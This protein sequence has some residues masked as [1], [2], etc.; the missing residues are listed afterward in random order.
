M[1][2]AAAKLTLLLI[3]SAN[4]SLLAQNRNITFKQKQCTVKYV[5]DIIVSQTNVD[6]LY[7]PRDFHDAPLMDIDLNNASIDDAMDTLK[8]KQP[9]LIFNFT[10]NIITVTR[11]YFDIRGKVITQDELPAVG[12]TV[13]VLGTRQ[14][15]TT[16]AGGFYYL[17]KVD[18]N[19]SLELTSVYTVRR[20]VRILNKKPELISVEKFVREL[21]AVQIS[22]NSGYVKIS[23]KT[24]AAPFHVI[25]GEILDQRVSNSPL[26]QLQGTT[27]GLLLVVNKITGVNQAN[28][29][30][31]GP[32]NTMTS[33][34]NALLI[35]DNFPY[36][37]K[38][39][40]LNSD[41]IESITVMKD[42][43][44]TS[45]WGAMGG[46][47][48]LVITTKAPRFSTPFTFSFNTW[49]STAAKPDLHHEDLLGASGMVDIYQYLYNKNF[50]T[51]LINARGH[52]AL[53]P[54]VEILES[55][56]N[57][58]IDQAQANAQLNMLRNRDVRAEQ[59]KYF[60]RRSFAGNF[61]MNLAGGSND[62][63]WAIS[64]SYSHS[65]PE[66]QGSLQQRAT[67]TAFNKY[68]FWKKFEISGGLAF[69][70]HRY[71]NMDNLPAIPAPDVQLADNNGIPV[72][73]PFVLRTGYIDTA[74][75]G[76]LLDWRYYPLREFL[77]RNRT[78]DEKNLRIS[79]GL[80]YT[81]RAGLDVSAL[82]QYQELGQ[83]MNTFHDQETFF[84]RDLVNRYT[85][86]GSFE[87]KIPYGNILDEVNEK[88]NVHNLRW[89]ITY[90]K[91]WSGNNSI[92]AY[93]GRDVIKTNSNI[94]TGR[95]YAYSETLPG[96][97]NALDYTTEFPQYNNTSNR[98][99]IPLINTY[100]K[101]D[102]NLV[103]YYANASYKFK[104]HYSISA[105]ARLD[106]SNLYGAS[107][108][109]K[110]LPLF[111]GGINWNLSNEKFYRLWWLPELKWHI[112]YGSSGNTP[113]HV[114]AVSTIVYGGYN[115]NGD[116]MAA[117]NNP[118]VGSLRWE[119]IN[120]LNLGFNFSVIDNI[121]Q[122]S[123]DW[124]SRKANHLVGYKE[125]DPTS[126]NSSMTGNVASMASNNI[127]VMLSSRII[128]Q[129]F[130]WDVSLLFSFLN[131]KVK[132]YED[133]L[134]PA[135]QYCEP[136]MLTIVPNKPLYG[137]FSFRYRGLNEQGQP[138]G[139]FNGQESID[140]NAIVM[141]MGY[142]T[143]KYH[144]R[145]TPAIFGNLTNNFI[146]KRFSLSVS[147]QYKLN[148][149][150]RR[151]SAYYY[152]IFMSNEPA[153]GDV[154]RRWQ[155]K[156]DEL[157]THVPSFPV[158]PIELQND[159]DLLYNFSEVLV[160]RGDHVRLENIYMSYELGNVVLQSLKLRSGSVYFNVSNAGIIW[161]ANRYKIDPDKL[162]GY[163]QPCTI[164]IGVKATLK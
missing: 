124:Y 75:G 34:P 79:G 118:P 45:V 66:T 78:T 130:Q 97:Q 89:M 20:V 91:T 47:G 42:A 143:L 8:L 122:G 37:G 117:I 7:D 95:I 115:S 92:N 48:V 146:Y 114:A 148:Y 88:V 155:A 123:I 33:S 112:T 13:T 90:S 85:R 125:L 22:G 27:P 63:S 54:A 36:Q 106:H 31:I 6:F 58:D 2:K 3:V 11:K 108:R 153:Y 23:R 127:D 128:R 32:R 164:S 140:Y 136:K 154:A 151:N 10:G 1:V 55:L 51:P 29:Y 18:A 142:E 103:S 26:K 144:G 71:H 135:W 84:V 65:L 16:D 30:T 64:G 81:I 9:Y 28:E 133:T 137:I 76:N 110:K 157:S 60:M 12:I 43:L 147:L 120:T 96:G 56:K 70:F 138:V 15:V 74:G 111:S 126:G 145:S 99:T 149:F 67:A 17:S 131:E 139:V 77:L 104:N 107:T 49:A 39:D 4:Y 134:L 41:D 25:P 69:T 82:Y 152:G 50:Y 94:S 80:K 121:V 40:D 35:V 21:S 86:P 160:E 59:E 158:G 163:P 68:R 100:D 161:R 83:D 53:P 132:H 73:Y 109:D 46:N 116:R 119:K 19:D 72:S 98:Y 141:R 93:A 105:S 5:I 129:P 44:S 38:I 113:T 156:G 162:T 159:R 62:Y 52:A 101:S 150:F 87:Q 57:G 24:G 14:T 61:S 102:R